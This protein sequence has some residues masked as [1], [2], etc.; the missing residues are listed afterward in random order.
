MAGRKRKSSPDAGTRRVSSRNKK[1]ASSSSHGSGPS[2]GDGLPDVYRHMIR[3]A[4]KEAARRDQGSSGPPTKRRR[5]GEKAAP[6]EPPQRTQHVVPPGSHPDTRRDGSEENIE[7]V[8]STPAPN[9]QT[10][11]LD[12]D[13]D[14][15]DDEDEDIEF[16]DVDIGVS[17]ASKG[18]RLKDLELNL[19]AAKADATAR[20]AMH[21]R[22][23]FT[24]A[25]KERRVEIHKMH[26]LCLLSHVQRRNHWC[27]DEDV[28]AALRPLLTD[29][30]VKF[31]KPSVKLNQYSQSE[32]LKNGVSETRIMFQSQYEI[33]ERGLRRALWAE[34]KEQLKDVCRS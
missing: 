28:Q 7:H 23:T 14:G 25:E 33:V 20:R 2:N 15:D 9:L 10:M 19:T 3:D 5:P 30:M 16:E 21:R 22:K 11:E 26:L 31:L 17:S 32:A 13:D 34:D 4:E 27:N 24:K 1:P 18:P 12:S 29:K 6:I 8:F